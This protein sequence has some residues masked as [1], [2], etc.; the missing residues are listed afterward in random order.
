MN[1]EK[2]SELTMNINLEKLDV[3]EKL[4]S[5]LELGIKLSPKYLEFMLLLL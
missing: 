3:Q 4:A 1:K 5:V 2:G